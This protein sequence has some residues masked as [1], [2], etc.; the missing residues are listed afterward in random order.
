MSRHRDEIVA[1]ACLPSCSAVCPATL[2]AHNA[3]GQPA[4]SAGKQDDD[5]AQLEAERQRALANVPAF[6]GGGGRSSGRP[7]FGGGAKSG[8]GAAAQGRRG[9]WVSTQAASLPSFR[10]DQQALD[11]R[12]AR[13][14]AT[15]SGA[16]AEG[17]EATRALPVPAH[18]SGGLT[19]LIHESPSALRGCWPLSPFA[20][21]MHDTAPQLVNGKLSYFDLA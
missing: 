16:P 8:D 12:E 18:T 19:R 6:L 13:F 2:Q 10:P 20:C 9:K 14:G 15:S 17:L 3:A 1:A 11:K 5:D 21:C 7:T 4:A